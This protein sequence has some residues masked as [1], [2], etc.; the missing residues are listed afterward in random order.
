MVPLS[1]IPNFGY[2]SSLKMSFTL[3]VASNISCLL[4]TS[5]TYAYCGPPSITDIVGFSPLSFEKSIPGVET[6]PST[7]P[8]LL[9][10][11]SSLFSMRANFAN[12]FTSSA[13]I[14][15][16]VSLSFPFT[17]SELSSYPSSGVTVNSISSPSYASSLLA[18]TVPWALFK[19][20]T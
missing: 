15:K 7:A 13:G 16:V 4:Y 17:V 9:P 19:I 10:C 12:I 2:L 5:L 8:K 14:L 18:V 11:T 3:N 1:I 6:Y 20:S